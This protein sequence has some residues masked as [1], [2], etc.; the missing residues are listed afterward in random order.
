MSRQ[1]NEEATKFGQ[2]VFRQD[3]TCIV[4]LKTMTYF[5]YMTQKQQ[6]QLAW[7][8][9]IKDKKNFCLQHTN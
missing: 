7:S 1:T 8:A 9:Q 4:A 6:K 3:E 5:V 2:V